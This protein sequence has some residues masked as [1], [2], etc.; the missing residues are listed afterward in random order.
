MVLYDGFMFISKRCLENILFVIGSIFTTALVM[1]SSTVQAHN[2][3][4]GM[5][6]TTSSALHEMRNSREQSAQSCQNNSLASLN[7]YRQGD[8][9]CSIP[10]NRDL[11]LDVKRSVCTMDKIL[12]EEEALRVSV[13]LHPIDVSKKTLVTDAC[14]ELQPPVIIATQK[15]HTIQ[16]IQSTEELETKSELFFSSVLDDQIGSSRMTCDPSMELES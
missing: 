16:P 12:T 10:G 7:D 4:I 6:H 11:G 1:I 5:A 2:P 8:A 14:P 13:L 9:V 3:L 15:L